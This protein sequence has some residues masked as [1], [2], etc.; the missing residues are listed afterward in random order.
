MA[1]I[2][3]G[4]AKTASI[5]D[6]EK[7]ENGEHEGRLVYVA[8][9]GMHEAYKAGPE[10]ADKPD[11]QKICLGIEAVGNPVQ[12]NGESQPRIL[13]TAPINIY[14]ELTELGN[15][16]KAYRVFDPQA[17]AGSVADW[18]SVLGSPCNMVIGKR[19]SGDGTKEY[20][21][22]NSLTPIP[23]KYQDGVAE[24]ITTPCV[25]D[26]DDASNPCTMALFGL[27]KYV[28]EKRITDVPF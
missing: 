26:S 21:N 24:A 5:E 22:I 10:D 25:G 16:L 23:A 9:L 4:V 11:V 20:D 14:Q 8:D 27:A 18:D 7:L 19:K 15:E 17:Q 3:K 1:L 28:Y 13:W 12:I 6:Y 2:R